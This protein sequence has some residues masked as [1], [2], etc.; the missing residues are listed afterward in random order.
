MQVWLVKQIVCHRILCN[1]RRHAATRKINGFRGFSAFPMCLKRC[2]R[3][4]S[5]KCYITDDDFSGIK[6][7]IRG[8]YWRLLRVIKI[9]FQSTPTWSYCDLL[10]PEKTPSVT[11]RRS[12]NFLQFVTVT[13]LNKNNSYLCYK[14]LLR[15]MVK[16]LRAHSILV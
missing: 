1:F 11:Y 16:S 15:G 2:T 14:G 5:P 9:I 13:R 12:M 3:V 4:I 7:R 6:D 10:F 8:S